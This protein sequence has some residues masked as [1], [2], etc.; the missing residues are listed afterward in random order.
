MTMSKMHRRRVFCVCPDCMERIPDE[1]LTVRFPDLAERVSPGEPVPS[2]E[3]PR[4]GALVHEAGRRNTGH[5][6]DLACPACGND[7]ALSIRVRT[8]M[9][10]HDGG[11]GDHGDIE[12]D[13]DSECICDEC[14]LCL[15]VKFYRVECS[16]YPE[17]A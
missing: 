3:C 8:W 2:G 1:E 13:D 12:W 15:P 4:C 14:K 6:E 5:L 10:V 7:E 16:E 9:L 17:K 11:S